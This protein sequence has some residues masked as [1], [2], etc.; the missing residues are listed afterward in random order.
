MR[1]REL[2][3]ELHEL[4]ER[5]E[6]AEADE[7]ATASRCAKAEAENAWL[8]GKLQHFAEQEEINIR[9]Q[10]QA[11][12]WPSRRQAEMSEAG[13]LSGEK[14]PPSATAVAGD[15]AERRRRHQRRKKQAAM[16]RGGAEGET[17]DKAAARRVATLLRQQHAPST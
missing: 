9:R 5:V 1:R 15:E 4:R 16:A 6:T 3:R 10:A 8:L 13:R 11:R 17:V 2:L 14:G 12:R 7:A